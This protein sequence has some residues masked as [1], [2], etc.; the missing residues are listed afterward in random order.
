MITPHHFLT[1][2]LVAATLTALDS[3]GASAAC[4]DP[5]ETTGCPQTRAVYVN[6]MVNIY[7]NDSRVAPALSS[8]ERAIRPVVERFAQNA[9]RSA[10]TADTKSFAAIAMSHYRNLSSPQAAHWLCIEGSLDFIL[11]SIGVT[12]TPTIPR[13]TNYLENL[14]PKG[15]ENFRRIGARYWSR[16]LQPDSTSTLR[17]PVASKYCLTNTAGQ[18]YGR[19]FWQTVPDD[20]HTCFRSLG[21]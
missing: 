14:T 20:Q 19:V 15:I 4:L 5:S 21:A 9:R 16:S 3:K 17:F 2:L 13:V 12:P 1:T 8:C 6:W 10:E 7:A 11:N 18:R